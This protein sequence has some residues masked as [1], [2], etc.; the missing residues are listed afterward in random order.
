MIRASLVGGMLRLYKFLIA[1]RR[2]RAL[3]AGVEK[4]EKS[5][6]CVD[7]Q[8]ISTQNSQRK[9]VAVIS[10]TN[11]WVLGDIGNHNFVFYS[12]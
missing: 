3:Q 4:S 6:R 11:L 9:R 12:L 2:S 1:Q 5:D 8:Y 7:L 10:P